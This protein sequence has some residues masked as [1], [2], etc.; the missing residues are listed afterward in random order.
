MPPITVVA[1]KAPSAMNTPWPKFSTSIRPNTSVR[2]EAMTK[3]ISPI[4]RPATV[5]VSQAA[6][7][8]DGRQRQRHHAAS[9]SQRLPV[10]AGLRDGGGSGRPRTGGWRCSLVRSQRQPSRRCCRPRPRPV[11][12][13]AAV[14]DAAVVHHRHAVA[15]RLGHHE[16]LLHQQDRGLLAFSS[17][18][19]S[20]RFWMIDGAR[21]LLGSSI[22]IS[23]RG[24]TM[25]RA[26]ASIC[27]CPPRAC[28][29]GRARTSS[30]PGRG[31][32]SSPAARV[33]LAGVARAG[34]RPAPCSPSPSGR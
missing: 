17:R 22:R 1:M 32:R 24:S 33:Q 3:M 8:A 20:I 10:E 4:A 21:P 7:A 15:Q 19:A 25:A 31:R 9:S 26:T 11:R 2:P 34:A 30:A 23:A 27:F 29:P 14:H 28:P 16:V 5:S 13:C 18:K 12:P 6:G